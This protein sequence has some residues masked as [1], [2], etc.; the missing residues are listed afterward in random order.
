MSPTAA[1]QLAGA[2][3]APHAIERAPAVHHW[4]LHHRLTCPSGHVGAALIGYTRD[5]RPIVRYWLGP[6]DG[7]AAHVHRAHGRRMAALLGGPLQEAP[8]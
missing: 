4:T 3:A 1:R 6:A 8:L 7:P 2:A 5:D